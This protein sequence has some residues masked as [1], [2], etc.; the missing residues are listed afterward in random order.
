MN[1]KRKTVLVSLLQY[2]KSLQE[3]RNDLK[4]IP[5]DCDEELVI[6]NG[7]HISKVLKR[8]VKGE[9]SKE[10]IE[11]WANLIEGR[12]DIEIEMAQ[13]ELVGNIINHM[14]N[15]E[16]QGTLTIDQANVWLD[17]L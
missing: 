8:F 14:A 1:T 7:N 15:P 5:W 11:E 6:L 16:L 3:H 4:S 10:E 12:E 2:D 13:E 9:L 17:S